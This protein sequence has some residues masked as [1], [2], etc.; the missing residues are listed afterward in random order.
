MTWSKYLLLFL[1]AF[2]FAQQPGF[3]ITA[4]VPAAANKDVSLKSYYF[5]E[6]PAMLSQAKADSRGN[7]TLHYPSSYKGAA[8]LQIAATQSVIVLLNKENFSMVWNDVNDFNSLQI[9]NSPEKNSFARGLG[10]YKDTEAKKAGL[11][12]LIPLYRSEPQKQ[13][14]FRSE[15]KEQ[16]MALSRFFSGLPV[17]SYSRYYLSVRMLLANIQKAGSTYSD[18]LQGYEQAFNS[19][20]FGD[21]QLLRSGL[22]DE[23]LDNYFILLESYGETKYSHINQSTDS[24]LASLQNDPSSKQN[25][26]EYLF[27]LFEKRS[28]FPAA[29]HIAVAMLSDA[30]C[31]PDS[32]REALIELYRKMAIGNVAPDIVF[33]N[34]GKPAKNL[35]DVKAKYRLVVFGA[36]WCPAC[37]EDIPKLKSFYPQWKSKYGVEV[38]FV[39]LDTDKA[40][41]TTFIN[42]FPW[43]STTDLKGWEGKAA[44]DYYVSGTPKMYLLGADHTILLKPVLPEQIS[45]WRQL[46]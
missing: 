4:S 7:F 21:L 44:R 9:A 22:Y 15:L 13:E 28:L 18:G 35:Y 10:V 6:P 42:S 14:M 36:S 25:V 40:A 16:D 32:R 12:Y 19:L 26:A 23:L 3:T 5:G 43:I 46:Q 17:D 38:I 41:Y 8:L 33:A 29:E 45:A 30:N 20:N 2:A 27:K 39:S 37:A 1:T 24:I 11:Q 34:S 31:Q